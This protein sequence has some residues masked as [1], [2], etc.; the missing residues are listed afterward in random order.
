MVLNYWYTGIVKFWQDERAK[1]QAE[2]DRKAI[3]NAQSKDPF[4]G[5]L[6]R[7]AFMKVEAN[8]DLGFVNKKLVISPQDV[9]QYSDIH[10]DTLRDR[11]LRTIQRE[12]EHREMFSSGAGTT[13]DTWRYE[14]VW[15]EPLRPPMLSPVGWWLV[16]VDR[17]TWYYEFQPDGKVRWVDPNGGD[18]GNGKWS[19][20]GDLLKITWASRS[21]DEWEYPLRSIDQPGR[22]SPDY[23]SAVEILRRL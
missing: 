19:A 2:L 9:F 8:D 6:V 11:A 1:A 15:I 17:W 13:K 23:A 18:N 22:S 10:Y 16:Q 12:P 5:A 14:I 3:F 20:I 4:T 21:Y 7:F